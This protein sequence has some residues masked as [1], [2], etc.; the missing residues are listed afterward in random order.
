[1]SKC[2]T[3]VTVDKPGEPTPMTSLFVDYLTFP[4]GNLEFYVVVAKG[5]SWRM[6]KAAKSFVA[7]SSNEFK[8]NF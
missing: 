7:S 8:F 5:A 1:M 2:N 6:V 3:W 4:Y